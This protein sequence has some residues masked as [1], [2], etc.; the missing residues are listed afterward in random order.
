MRVVRFI[1]LAVFGL[2]PMGA[3]AQGAAQQPPPTWEMEAAIAANYPAVGKSPS[4]RLM[5]WL[6]H[7][8]EHYGKLVSNDR[9]AGVVP[10]V[11][12]PK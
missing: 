7:Q 3:F 12:R 2:A 10:P 4:P 8:A 6:E 1:S 5:G 11:S 9:L